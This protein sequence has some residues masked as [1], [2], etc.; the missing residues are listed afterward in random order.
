MA[1][2]NQCKAVA[3]VFDVAVNL[4]ESNRKSDAIQVC[5][6]H[7]EGYS[8][9]I[10]FPYQIVNGEIVYDEIFAQEGKHDIFGES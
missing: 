8:A 1:G 9:E 4:P 2:T 10:F 3:I 7:A 5:V 6:D